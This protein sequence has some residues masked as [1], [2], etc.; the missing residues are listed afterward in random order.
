MGCQSLEEQRRNNETP[1]KELVRKN[2]TP[3]NPDGITK[4]TTPGIRVSPRK[5]NPLG[6]SALTATPT[7][8]A[9]AA[10]L[11][12]EAPIGK[13]SYNAKFRLAHV[14]A[15][16]ETLKLVKFAG[17]TA[18]KEQLDTRWINRGTHHQN[19]WEKCSMCACV[20]NN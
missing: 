6:V 2:A 11:A 9:T 5:K 19:K 14:I 20:S 17:Q 7:V 16:Q 8:P 18:T 4:A 1:F 3:S 13:F 15:D 12:T 10:A